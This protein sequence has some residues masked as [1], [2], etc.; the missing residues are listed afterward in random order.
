MRENRESPPSPWVEGVEGRRGKA[1]GRTPRMYEGG[2]SD[3]PVVPA[4]SANNGTKASAEPMEGRGGA[5]G[6][7]DQQTTP[8]TQNRTGVPHALERVRQAAKR[9]R[10]AKFTALMH[11]ITVERLRQ[12][13][14]ELK[15]QAAPGID[16]VTWTQ[17]QKNLETNLRN[18]WDRVQK[19]TYQ[20]KP[21]RRVYIPKADGTQRPLGIAALEDKIVQ[22]AMAQ[23]LNAIYEAD[24]LGFSYGF[25]S[26]RSQHDALD[27]LAVG[28]SLKK[29]NYVLDADI[30]GFYESLDQGWLGQFV[31]HRIADPRVQRLIQKWMRAGVMEAGSY[32]VSEAGV[33]QG[34][35]LSPLLANLYLHY[36]LDLWVE[37]WRKQK[38]RGDV[39]VVRFADDAIFGFQHRA[40]AEKFLGDL[41]ERLRTFAL[42]LHPEKTR[43][44]EF[45]RYATNRRREQGL[46]KPET[47][48]FLGFTHICGVSQK[49]KFLLKR[50]TMRK[51]MR[52]R[53]KGVKDEL[54]RRRHD[55]I[56]EQGRW[57]GSVVRGYFGYHAV[58]TN[59]H[60]LQSFRTQVERHWLRSLQRR[61]Q[62]HR[63]DWTK[64]RRLSARYLPAPRILHPW[65]GARFDVKTRGKSPVR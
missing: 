56:P 58:P 54:L 22:R 18:L 10:K 45:G 50:Q 43:L 5:K 53:L 62:R 9:D 38:A 51:R 34:A 6:N 44:I 4:K 39:I 19:G 47:F 49:G 48:D 35:S 59:I 13:C 33:P 26:G 23:V 36:V 31:E 12:A 7:T 65:P 28:L 57:L 52:Q 1:R 25:R 24:F 40:E 64:M 16:G 46:G 63:L 2:Q 29:V 8:R 17:Y 37:Q 60:A 55:P 15:R 32:S 42:E 61:S 27:A 20:A 30:R 21:S 11:H 14:T 3:S 41:R